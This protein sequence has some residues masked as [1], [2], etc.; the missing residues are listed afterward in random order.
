MDLD[1]GR[2]RITALLTGLHLHSRLA[3]AADRARSAARR[4]PD[5]AS[6]SWSPGMISA[7]C[8]A[9][10]GQESF[11]MRVA[12]VGCIG[13]GK[14]TVATQLGAVTGLPVLHLDRYWWQDGR[15][16][17][18][19]VRSVAE[20]T[21]SAQ[22]FRELQHRLAAEN[23]WIIDGG[24]IADLD[25][26]LTRADTVVFLD[27]PRRVCL[28]RLVRRHGKHRA[29][30]PAHVQEGLGWLLALIRWVMSYPSQKRPAIEEAF[31]HYC[32]PS[33][34]IVRLQSRAQVDKFLRHWSNTNQ[35]TV[36]P[37]P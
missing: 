18:T 19:G 17:I 36:K 14:S 7:S 29:D 10:T 21:M 1:I 2:G 28:W 16:R 15:Y 25:T 6:A 5:R 32:G 8:L 24:Y 31:A 13:A 33:T 4:A 23:A 12:V 37:P 20:H 30:Y 22:A 11:V 26:R 35:N 34:E 9:A 3:K 27:L